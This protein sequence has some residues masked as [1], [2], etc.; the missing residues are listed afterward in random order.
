MHQ[1]YL[2]TFSEISDIHPGYFVIVPNSWT[3]KIKGPV[4]S[5]LK[6]V[7]FFNVRNINKKIKITFKNVFMS[8]TKYYF[9]FSFRYSVTGNSFT[10]FSFQFYRKDTTN[11]RIV[12]DTSDA[13]LECLQPLFMSTPNEEIWK[14]NTQRYF[15]LWNLPNCVAA[16][17]GKHIRVKKFP[18]S[19]SSNFNYKGYF[20]TILTVT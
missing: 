5:K 14:L 2:I 15:E 16:I 19:G 7:C 11:G 20:S 12:K 6:L 17:D 10:S 8:K 4:K 1:N 18:D 13:I 3:L 9:F